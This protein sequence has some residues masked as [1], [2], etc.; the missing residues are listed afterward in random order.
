MFGQVS[1]QTRWVDTFKFIESTLTHF[2]QKRKRNDF[3]MYLCLYTNAKTQEMVF[4]SLS[5]KL[6]A[7][8]C[9]STKIFL[10]SQSKKY[11]N[12]H[13]KQTDNS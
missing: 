1:L 12:F 7:I 10:S 5:V 3:K 11:H 13:N 9:L 4:D 8:N 2:N 6:V